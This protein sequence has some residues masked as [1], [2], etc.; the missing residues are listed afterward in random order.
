MRLLTWICAVCIILFTVEY[1]SAWE[2]DVHYGL[3]KWLAFEAGFSL[4]DAEAI[5]AGAEEPDEGKLYPAPTAVIK[6]ACLG[7]DSD[8]V[9]LV[10]KYHFPSYGAMPG[11]PGGRVVT[12][13]L[14]TGAATD[15]IDTEIQTNLPS[16]PKPLTLER[17]G[18]AL[19]PLEDSWAHQGVPDSPMPWVCSSDFSFGHPQARGGWR[20]HNADL[21]YLHPIPD[22]IQT[23]QHTYLKLE[24]FLQRH[25]ALRAHPAA[26]WKP[27]QGEVQRFAA[28]STK[29]E[30][31]AWF[32]SQTLVP[33]SS[34]TTYPDFLARISLPR[35]AKLNVAQPN[36]RPPA[37]AR[38]QMVEYQSQVPSNVR[39]FIDGFLNKWIVD[40][41]L[42]G[43]LSEV[44]PEELA[45]PF[46]ES[47]EGRGV[48]S[49]TLTRDL[50]AM[51]LVADHGLVS[52]LGHGLNQR[53]ETRIPLEKFPM[54]Q[55]KTLRSAISYQPEPSRERAEP[56]PY[57][58]F[59]VKIAD[60]RMRGSGEAYAVLFQF[61]HAPRDAIV[62]LVTQNPN[63]QW[64]VSQMMWWVL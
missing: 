45:R 35:S 47:T 46:I 36:D 40:R 34:Y 64:R 30:K 54:I 60:P 5:A 26:S 25:P 37:F 7:R 62:L 9:R 15:L 23:A 10:Q 43:V 63:H 41:N 31:R 58:V 14:S 3:T 4:E 48:N 6:A 12:P 16:R 42:D 39:E 32:S 13:G 53:P 56:A 1:A 27:L 38:F 21:T 59:S 44:N 20:S 22:T 57:G 19:H 28:A 61:R 33:L 55:A 18:V 2:P 17:L 49:Y 50:L 29:D 8:V 52:S 11:A 24:E 51:C